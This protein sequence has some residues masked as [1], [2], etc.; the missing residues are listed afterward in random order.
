MQRFTKVLINLPRGDL[1]LLGSVRNFQDL[2][3]LN[4]LCLL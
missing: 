3:R 2:I 1:I 4:D